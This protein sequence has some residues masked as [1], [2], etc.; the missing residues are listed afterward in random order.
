MKTFEEAFY[1][2]LEVKTKD[3][4]EDDLTQR[5]LTEQ[6]VEI[7]ASVPARRWALS[8]ADLAWEKMGEEVGREE[9]MCCFLS[10][11]ASGVRIGIEMEKE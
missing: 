3:S 2:A 7:M 9:I 1:A 11:L 10:G 8:M 6:A 5:N 4:R